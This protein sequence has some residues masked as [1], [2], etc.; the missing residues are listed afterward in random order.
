MWPA[1]P[2]V[3][4]KETEDRDKMRD[5]DLKPKEMAEKAIM[6]Q[7]QEK[8]AD[9]KMARGEE[10]VTKHANEHANVLEKLGQKEGEGQKE[11]CCEAGESTHHQCEKLKDETQ[12]LESFARECAKETQGNS[13]AEGQES[14]FD[15]E[16]HETE[17]ETNE[18]T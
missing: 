15:G 6:P 9:R 5:H 18:V 17:K 16:G 7:D 12:M 11:Q 1:L 3:A 13:E 14:Q 2:N 4:K 8:E 10:E